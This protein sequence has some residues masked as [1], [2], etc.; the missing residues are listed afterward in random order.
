MRTV[1][2]IVVLLSLSAS[3]P[4]VHEWFIDRQQRQ[5]VAEAAQLQS[6]RRQLDDARATITDLRR[7]CDS[8]PAQEEK[9]KT[10]ESTLAGVG[11]RLANFDARVDSSLK[12]LNLLHQKTTKIEDKTREGAAHEAAKAVEAVQADVKNRIEFVEG[13]FRE[14]LKRIENI[15]ST[16]RDDRDILTMRREMLSPIVQLN[17]DDTVGSGVLIYSQKDNNNKITS[18][19]LS[20]YHVV[21]NIIAEGGDGAK[22]KGIRLNVYT[23]SGTNAEVA[24]MVAFDE[25]IDLVLLKLRGERTYKSVARLMTPERAAQV[26]VFSPIY[27]VGCPLGNDPIPTN[28][29]V[30]SLKNNVSNHNYWMINAPTYFGNSGGGVFLA[31]SHELIGIFS[32]IYTHGTGRPTVIPHMGLATPMDAIAPFLEKNGYDFIMKNATAAAAANAT[33][34]DPPAPANK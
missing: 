29:E 8:A 14:D 11:T 10:L 5:R 32:K 27:A 15:Q 1:V 12:E 21:R 26:S 16:T 31:K 28:G 24:D 6:L 3:I 23:D 9:L 20:S 18:L 19:I 22:E 17:G 4:L 33:K 7:V 13:R 2:P 34:Q 30:A 25:G